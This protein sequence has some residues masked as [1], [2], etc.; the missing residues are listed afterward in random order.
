MNE[1]RGLSPFAQ[2]AE[3]KGTVPLSGNGFVTVPQTPDRK[4]PLPTVSGCSGINSWFLVKKRHCNAHP[5]WKCMCHPVI[6]RRANGN[7]F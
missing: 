1:K 4:P 7:R 2:S 3:Q 6:R 5:M